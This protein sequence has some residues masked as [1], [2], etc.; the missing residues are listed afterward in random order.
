MYKRELRIWEKS[1]NRF[2]YISTVSRGLVWPASHIDY[3][4]AIH[5]T[6]CESQKSEI[7]NLLNENILALHLTQKKFTGSLKWISFIWLVKYKN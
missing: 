3:L 4:V 1:K 2:S 7:T 5:G 6:P